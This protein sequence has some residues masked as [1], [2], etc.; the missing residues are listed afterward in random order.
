MKI[1][2]NTTAIDVSFNLSGSLR[3]LIS[4]LQQLPVGKKVGFDT[5]PK[6]WEDVSD[7]GQTWTPDLQGRDL[8]ITLPVYNSAA[9][10]KA[11]FTSPI[12]YLN[13]VA[14]A[15]NALLESISDVLPN[16]W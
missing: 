14:D 6:I 5:L 4:V 13:K 7:I 2:D 8:D 3:G 10:Q 9:M 1:N 11:P 16:D 12:F 15:G